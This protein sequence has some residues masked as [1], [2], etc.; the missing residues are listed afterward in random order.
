MSQPSASF[1][2]EAEG[3][4]L[5]LDQPVQLIHALVSG[6]ELKSFQEKSPRSIEVQE[7]VS[8]C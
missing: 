6:N 1:A 3:H 2:D 4:T 7:K 8:I 5:E